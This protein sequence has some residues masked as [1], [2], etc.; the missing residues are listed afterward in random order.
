MFRRHFER[1]AAAGGRDQRRPF[2]IRDPEHLVNGVAE[3]SHSHGMDLAERAGLH[4]F[5]A[6]APTAV[7]LSGPP[8]GT[9]GNNVPGAFAPVLAKPRRPSA[10]R[11]HSRSAWIASAC[12]KTSRRSPGAA[13]LHRYLSRN[14]LGLLTSR[15]PGSPVRHH[16]GFNRSDSRLTGS[17]TIA[18]VRP[19]QCVM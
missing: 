7:V 16:K 14:P 17:K 12:G 9:L 3:R 8:P 1:I 18:A 6:A 2:H 11:V 19:A 4:H 10:T 5:L 15:R 13:G